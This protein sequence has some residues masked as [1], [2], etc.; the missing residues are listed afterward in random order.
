MPGV[1]IKFLPALSAALICA[2][3]DAGVARKKLLI[4]SEVPLPRPP[5]VQVVPE[6]FVLTAGENTK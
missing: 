1:R 6:E 5:D 3:V 4:G 2:R